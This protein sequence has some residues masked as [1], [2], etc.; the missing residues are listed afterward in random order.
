[1]APLTRVKL[2]NGQPL[3]AKGQQLEETRL[4]TL[5]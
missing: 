3:D 1:M 5:P 4:Q 2:M